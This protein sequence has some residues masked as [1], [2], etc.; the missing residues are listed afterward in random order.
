MIKVRREICENLSNFIIYYMFYI[1]KVKFRRKKTK[2]IYS[3]G[4][5][6][7]SD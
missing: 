7:V 6:A 4:L 5:A 3:S 2:G 1:N